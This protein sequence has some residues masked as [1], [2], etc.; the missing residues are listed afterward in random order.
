[1]TCVFVGYGF[2]RRPSISA[3]LALVGGVALGAIVVHASCEATSHVHQ[4][5]SHALAPLIAAAALVLPASLA[6]RLPAGRA[7]REAPT[8]GRAGGQGGR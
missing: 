8:S 3:A 7:R 4:L 2:L 5:V 1:M 6:L